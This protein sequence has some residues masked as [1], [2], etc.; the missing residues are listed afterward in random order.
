MGTHK[1]EE[2]EDHDE[3]KEAEN[4]MVLP[5]ETARSKADI[6]RTKL[7]QEL[8]KP[9]NSSF[10]SL[11]NGAAL[12]NTR[13]LNKRLYSQTLDPVQPQISNDRIF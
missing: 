11:A 1:I 4:N 10:T 13:N 6:M 8:N 12:I 9:G 5:R 2:L 3:I 7:H